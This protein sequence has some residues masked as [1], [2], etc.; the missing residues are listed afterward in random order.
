MVFHPPSWIPQLP[1]EPPDSISILDF[2]RNEKY[3][4]HPLNKSF[5][6][7]TCGLTGKSYS[8]VEFFERSEYLAR[9]FSKR[10]AWQPNE[11]TA[12]D[13]VACIF[14]LNNVSHES[15]YDSKCYVNTG[16]LTILLRHTASIDS[17]ALLRQQTRYTQ[18]MNLNTSYGLRHHKF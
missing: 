8:A 9:S 7:F 18:L 16:R 12:W 1:I 5:P 6:P 17:Q 10:L 4:R 14:A 11:G 2:M 13:K 15:G 3:G